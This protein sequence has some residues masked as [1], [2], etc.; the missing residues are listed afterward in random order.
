MQRLVQV[1]EGG[2]AQNKHYW[3]VLP[4]FGYLTRMFTHRSFSFESMQCITSLGL[5]VPYFNSFIIST[6]EYIRLV[7]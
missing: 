6:G 7:T 3:N 2:K 5:V 4:V 1:V